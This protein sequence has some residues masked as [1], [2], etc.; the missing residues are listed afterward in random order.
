M[1]SI[2]IFRAQA[3]PWP[4]VLAGMAVLLVALALIYRDTGIAMVSIW[5][6]SE[7]FAHAFLVPP[8]AAWLI[9]ERRH[10]AALEQP[11]PCAWVLLPMG[12]CAALWLLGELT[13][14]NAASQLA[15]V[16][17]LVLTVPLM[18]GLRVARILAFPLCFLFFAV[19]IGEFL[20]PQLMTWTADFTALALRL[21]GIP[22]FHEGQQLIIPT[23]TWSVVEACSGVR[24]L[25]ASFMVGVLFAN[26]NYQSL[27]RRLIFVALS[28]IV[29]VVANW[30][31][32]YTVILLGHYSGNRLAVGVDHLIYGW[33]FFGVVIGVMYLIGAR[34]AEPAP[35]V[36]KRAV[37]G[38]RAAGRGARGMQWAIGIAA[39]VLVSLPQFG[40]RA[41]DS[42]E[43]AGPPRLGEP[44][45]GA[46][47]W[48]PASSPVADWTPAYQNPSA[49]LQRSYTGKAGEVGLYIGYYRH[50][51]LARK[52]IAS[53]NTLVPSTDGD[54]LQLES[55]ARTVEVAQ[56]P[57]DVRSA[58]LRS[59][60]A[61]APD[62]R[63]VVWQFYWIGGTLTT[64][65]ARAKL[66]SAWHRAIGDGDDSAVVMV[67]AVEK[68]AG[69]A[70]PR[71]ASFL[72]ANLGAT[73]RALQ[74][75]HDGR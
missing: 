39:A 16:A 19:P 42:G 74:E 60:A 35:A 49:Q 28:L 47:G 10:A 1:S 21:T 67:Y 26:L 71:L 30:L 7:T 69:A 29:P 25:I 40:L 22:V 58:R 24:Y 73:L 51:T 36:A 52:L 63:L 6:R 14:S 44:A 33:L 38:Q 37:G 12:L 17:L 13:A 70:E 45:V 53:T 23:G 50:Q 65:D 72:Q 34:W 31:R 59:K 9:W 41:L 43:S 57:L 27:H 18:A 54:W 32:A 46:L 64:S 61:S 5:I 4:P 8:V 55:S 11:A 48:Q 68:S 75:A 66:L 15:F 2:P 56:R 20:I 3:S 62:E